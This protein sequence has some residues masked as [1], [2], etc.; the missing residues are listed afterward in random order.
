MNSRLKELLEKELITLEEEQEIEEIEEVKEVNIVSGMC[1]KYQ[2][3]GATW[4]E[5]ILQ[6]GSNYDFYVQE[7]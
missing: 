5:A 2:D 1:Y 7:D 6:D 3:E 4:Y